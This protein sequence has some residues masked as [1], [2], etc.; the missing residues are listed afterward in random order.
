MTPYVVMKLLQYCCSD[1]SSPY[2]ARPSPEPMLI[3]FFH[4]NL[5]EYIKNLN[6]TF[7]NTLKILIKHKNL[8]SG[9]SI[10]RYRRYRSQC[11][12][13]ASGNIARARN[14]NITVQPWIAHTVYVFS[15][16]T[17]RMNNISD[18]IS[19]RFS[20]DLYCSSYISRV[21]RFSVMHL[22]I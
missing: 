19:S 12:G 11:I 7:M 18:K 3:Y 20:C 22:P 9:T 17:V 10:W 5:Y 13:L 16:L 4:L 14:V 6:K 21:C 8:L 2:R 1:E 15:C